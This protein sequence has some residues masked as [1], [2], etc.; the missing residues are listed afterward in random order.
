MKCWPWMLAQGVCVA[1][2]LEHKEEAGA[3]SRRKGGSLK[4]GKVPGQVLGL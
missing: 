1:Y 3:Q 2:I 4:L